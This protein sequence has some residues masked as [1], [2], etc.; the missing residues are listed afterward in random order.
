[1]FCA[2]VGNKGGLQSMTLFVYPGG[3]PIGC[4]AGLLNAPMID[5]L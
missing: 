3:A 4:A 1:M 5:A 2:L